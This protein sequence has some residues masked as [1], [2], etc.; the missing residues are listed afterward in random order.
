[1]ILALQHSEV[2]DDQ[3][4]LLLETGGTNWLDSLKEANMAFVFQMI[5]SIGGD[6]LAACWAKLEN[7]VVVSCN[8]CV[9]VQSAVSLFLQRI[10]ILGPTI[11][12]ERLNWLVN[13][14]V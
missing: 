2:A 13:V 8:K 14:L 7:V 3:E 1:M 6:A 5:Q 4:L 11:E 9:W 10:K 12:I